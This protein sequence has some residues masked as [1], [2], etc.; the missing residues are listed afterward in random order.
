[1]FIK[2]KGKRTKGFT[3]MEVLVTVIIIGVLATISYPIFNKSITK[4][5]ATEA[6]NLLEIVKTKQLH[7]FANGDGTY[8][9]DP[10][11]LGR[12][13]SSKEQ[14]SD[15]SIV[16]DDKYYLTLNTEK[17]CAYVTYKKG[18]EDIFTFSTAYETGGLGCSKSPAGGEEQP[19]VCRSFQGINGTAEEVCAADL[20]T[21]R[22]ADEQFDAKYACRNK[23]D[24]PSCGPG[25]SDPR[26]VCY[27][28][29]YEFNDTTCTWSGDCIY[30]GDDT[31]CHGKRELCSETNTETCYRSCT[32]K[33]W[34]GCT[35]CTYY[36][37]GV[38]ETQTNWNSTGCP[39]IC[40]A[41]R[42]GWVCD[43]N[44]APDNGT[45]YGDGYYC[46]TSS[47]CK[48]YFKDC[49]V[50]SEQWQTCDDGEGV[51]K[52][53]YTLREGWVDASD[54]SKGCSVLDT[55]ACE[56]KTA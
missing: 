16:V 46:Q 20:P 34:S 38:G 11:V 28:D 7:H 25:S 15:N 32:G 3:L 5:R 52:R 30:V 45:G 49:P 50:D 40:N 19:E 8:I 22:A 35:D 33:T 53:K 36:T 56:C 44:A 24:R 51:L 12:L 18:G 17:S 21:G 26:S 43:G 1:M 47:I 4:A 9:T 29:T 2:R 10:S 27:T 13:T 55:A 6:V 41:A 23:G 54:T 37:C 39:G 48:Q 14:L 42:D 31:C